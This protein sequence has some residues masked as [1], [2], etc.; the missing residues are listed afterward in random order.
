[1]DKELMPILRRQCDEGVRVIGIALHELTLADFS[2]RFDDGQCVG[3]E[4]FQCLPQGIKDVEGTRRNGLVPLTQ[5]PVVADAWHQVQKQLE[6]ALN[7]SAAPPARGVS[8]S[9]YAHPV[10]ADFPALAPPYLCDRRDQADL[11]SD[12]LAQWHE[13]GCHRPLLVLTE[14][15]EHDCLIEWVDRVSAFEVAQA[16]PLFDGGE[17]AFGDPTVFAWPTGV[18]DEADARRRLTFQFARML[19][20]NVGTPLESLQAEVVARRQPTFWWSELNLSEGEATLS[21]GLSAL[22]AT[23]AC[24]PDLAAQGPL[25]IA[26]NLVLDVTGSTDAVWAG[27]RGAPGFRLAELGRLPKVGKSDLTA[28]ARA[29][30]IRPR[31]PRPNIDALRDHLTEPKSMRDFVR[32]YD[33]WA[34]KG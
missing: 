6:A 2:V 20:R 8:A 13:L 32:L 30:H 7:D 19:G 11:L 21:L 15:D 17:L 25:V 26:L 22:A 1:M 24:W 9:P 33:D 34:A 29:P 14:G 12:T 31:L 16:L 27:L 5:W 10:A 23:L 28:W 4:D 3:L 18:R